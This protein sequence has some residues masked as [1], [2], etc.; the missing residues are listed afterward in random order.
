MRNRNQTK[1]NIGPAELDG[2]PCCLIAR[3]VCAIVRELKREF[4]KSA[5]DL[6]HAEDQPP[7]KNVVLSRHR[8]T[9][10]RR[11]PE[12]SDPVSRVENRRQ[13]RP[14]SVR[15]RV[16]EALRRNGPL[17]RIEIVHAVGASLRLP[18]DEQLEKRVEKILLDRADTRL[19]RIR[20]GVYEY[21]AAGER[22]AKSLVQA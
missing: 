16:Y 7:Q 17:R 3:I 22:A 14:G 1:P 21:A 20:R 9:K 18:A 10:T 15:D 13:V 2:P 6:A 4:N 12:M 19:R 11:V 8:D 5:F